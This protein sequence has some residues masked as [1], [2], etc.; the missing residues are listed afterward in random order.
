MN[1][2]F[3]FPQLMVRPEILPVFVEV[4]HGGCPQ[5]RT[6]LKLNRPREDNDSRYER[7]MCTDEIR[8]FS[9]TRRSI[10]S[11]S[12]TPPT[13]SPLQKSVAICTT[14]RLPVG[15]LPPKRKQLDDECNDKLIVVFRPKMNSIQ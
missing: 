15:L 5:Q 11:R 7:H 2:H 9:I 3:P 4:R 10:D 1:L 6:N 8:S 14:W 12:I 13:H